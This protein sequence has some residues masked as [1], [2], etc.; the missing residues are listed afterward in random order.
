[1][2][3]TVDSEMI[4]QGLT[5]RWSER[6]TGV[7]ST[8]EMISRL[9]FRATRA[10]VIVAALAFISCVDAA[11][12]EI[13]IA[14]GV[15]P[16]LGRELVLV[17]T[18]KVPAEPSTLRAVVR[19]IRSHADVAS[20]TV[21]TFGRRTE[22]EPYLRA[23]WSPNGRYV[24]FNLQWTRHTRETLVYHIAGSSM[25]RM[26]LPRYWPQAQRALGKAADFVGGTETPLRW[27]DDHTLIVRSTGSLRDER[28]FDLLVTITFA[29]SK[30]SIR[31]V[32]LY[33]ET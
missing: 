15:S 30:A 9:P 29:G 21:T 32:T 12:P 1:M 2:E 19:D 25:T 33:N 28:G 16:A 6:R 3:S 11:V 13:Q 10:L 4:R 8:F 27:R 23:A 7:R 18:A 22:S 17:P 20:D 24:A 14:G 5:M 31:S 26:E